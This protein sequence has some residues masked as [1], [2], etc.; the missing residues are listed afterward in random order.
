VLAGIAALGAILG[1]LLLEPKNAQH[2]TIALT[3]QGAAEVPA[4]A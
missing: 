4:A 1:V 2:D 3:D